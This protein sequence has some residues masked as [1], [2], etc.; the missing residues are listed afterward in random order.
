MNTTPFISK[1]DFPENQNQIN[2]NI[3]LKE[4]NPEQTTATNSQNIYSPQTIPYYPNSLP[5]YNNSNPIPKENNSNTPPQN[6]NPKITPQNYNQNIPPQNYNPNISAQ[7]NYNSQNIPSNI[8]P[9][10]P[11][12]PGIGNQLYDPKIPS[13]EYAYTQKEELTPNNKD[14][15]HGKC[16]QIHL[17]IISILMFMIIFID[18]ILFII[19]HYGKRMLFTAI[20]DIGI[21]IC[22]LLFLLSYKYFFSN[23]NK[24]NP[25]LRTAVT[26]FVWFCGVG[27][28]GASISDCEK[29]KVGLFIGV[30]IIRTIILFFSIPCSNIEF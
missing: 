7:T 17:L 14:Q 4:N 3:H 26:V 1:K 20:D 10:N 30:M 23:K 21:L 22:G 12:L 15:S 9:Y 5:E 13:Q 25:C 27:L 16:S 8:N 2:E 24:I 28:R 29:D 18:I 6:Y 19:L 11:N